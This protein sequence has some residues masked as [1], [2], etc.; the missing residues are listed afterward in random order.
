MLE[1][2]MVWPLLAI[3]DIQVTRVVELMELRS[4]E[5]AVVCLSMSIVNKF[6][7]CCEEQVFHSQ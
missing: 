6:C 5:A 1:K 3:L 7:I 4:V 2:K